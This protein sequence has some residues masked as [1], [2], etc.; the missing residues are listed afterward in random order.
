MMRRPLPADKT[1]QSAPY[2]P[3]TA[4]FITVQ[5]FSPENPTVF[6]CV[7]PSFLC[8]LPEYFCCYSILVLDFT[9]VLWC[10]K[11]LCFPSIFLFGVSINL[12]GCNSFGFVVP[13]VFIF[14]NICLFSV[15]VMG[16]WTRAM[17][18]WVCG[19]KLNP[20][21][22]LLLGGITC[23]LLGVKARGCCL[24]VVGMVVPLAVV[25]P[26]WLFAKATQDTIRLILNEWRI[27][28]VLFLRSIFGANVLLGWKFVLNEAYL[29]SLF[30][31]ELI[32]DQS[33]GSRCEIDGGKIT[34]LDR[35]I[36]GRCGVGGRTEFVGGR[37]AVVG[38][39]TYSRLGTIER[40][41]QRRRH[42]SSE[43]REEKIRNEMRGSGPFILGHLPT[44]FRRS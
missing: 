4:P 26:V 20:L 14:G 34:D 16:C 15:M 25:Y 24:L 27:L 38:G 31:V 36:G 19:L 3:V 10:W 40:D 32:L 42:S 17:M 29:I 9:L 5:N 8:L 18:W 41:R 6:A 44:V 11:V 1:T 30:W 43:E 33:K 2:P 22:A 23:C 12:G 13:A 39:K 7:H 28:F 37:R 21:V 35:A